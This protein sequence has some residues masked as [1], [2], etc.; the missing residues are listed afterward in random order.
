MGAQRT[1]AS[2]HVKLAEVT[3]SFHFAERAF[4]RWKTER[5]HRLQRKR[6]RYFVQ[7]R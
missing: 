5:C 6:S 2:K 4:K 1:F 7:T 3:Q